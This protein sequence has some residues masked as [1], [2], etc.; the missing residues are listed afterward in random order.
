MLND[1]GEITECEREGMLFHY[2][3]RLIKSPPS[4]P[5]PSPSWMYLEAVPSI[6]IKSSLLIITHETFCGIF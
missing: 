3:D 6:F 1:H 5:T 2:Y 4:T